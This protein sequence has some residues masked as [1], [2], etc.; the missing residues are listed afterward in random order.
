MYDFTGIYCSHRKNNKMIKEK[1]K[2]MPRKHSV[3]SL[4]KTCN[5][6][7]NTGS[8]AVR[9]LKPEPWGSP[10]VHEKYLVTGRKG[11]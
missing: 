1:L 6:T 8:T 2:A 7:R 11:L 9:I 3:D 4:Q 10:V 5:I